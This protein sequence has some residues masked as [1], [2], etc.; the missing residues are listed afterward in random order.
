MMVT[1]RRRRPWSRNDRRVVLAAVTG[2]ALLLVGAPTVAAAQP[3]DPDN[4]PRPTAQQL[5]S[6]VMRWDPAGAVRQ[7]DP[8][9][10]VSTLEEETTEGGETV[11]TLNA[12]ILFAFASAE[13]P[14]QAASR[15]AELIAAAPAGAAVRVEGHTD[16]IGDEAANLDLSRRRAE[17][18]AEVIRDSRD[19]LDLEVTGYGEARPVAPNEVGGDDNPAGRAQNRR[20]EIRYEH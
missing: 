5:T 13:V 16:S 11:L 4:L 18:V 15:V 6:S 9:G 8:R 19:D 20:V 14:P 12:D 10:H 3:D 7:W 2:V 1:S 17:A